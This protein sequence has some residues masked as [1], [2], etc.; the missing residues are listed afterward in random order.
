ML[1]SMEALK[2][3]GFTQSSSIII[4]QLRETEVKAGKSFRWLEALTATSGMYSKSTARW[5]LY[6]TKPAYLPALLSP[7]ITFAIFVA[8]SSAEYDVSRILTSLSL[9]QLITQPLSSLFQVVVPFVGAFACLTR[10][11]SYLEA[12]DPESEGLS[13]EGASVRHDTVMHNDVDNGVELTEPWTRLLPVRG[14]RSAK[15][16]II[17]KDAD[18]GWNTSTAVL[19]N[20]NATFSTSSFNFILGPVASGK[21][22]LIRA[23][24]GEAKVIRGSVVSPW[25]AFGLCDQ[26]PWLQSAT[27]RKNII[28]YSTYDPNWYATV[29]H[30]TC[31][32][33]DIRVMSKGDQTPVGDSGTALS[34]GQKKRVVRSCFVDTMFLR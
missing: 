10:I 15:P 2:M 4:K 11:G 21:S 1:S 26:K 17:I 14:Q 18:I 33:E 34:G 12:G 24:L 6:L 27:I 19:H 31:L 25:S 23:I 13:S 5:L 3:T 9:L 30:V 16:S 22:T 20:L 8:V 28:G 32:D 7:P 29:L